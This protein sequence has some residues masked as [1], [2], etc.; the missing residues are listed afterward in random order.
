MSDE[1]LYEIATRELDSEPHA[2]LW[3]KAMALSATGRAI[4]F[5]PAIHSLGLDR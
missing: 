1:H 3:T 2:G 5:T 4:G